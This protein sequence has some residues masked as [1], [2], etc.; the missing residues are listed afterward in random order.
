M[1]ETNQDWRKWFKHG[2]WFE[3]ISDD[4][5]QK[6][7]VDFEEIYQIFKERMEWEEDRKHD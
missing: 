1:S 4:T 3:V 2:R 6:E 5:C 7:I